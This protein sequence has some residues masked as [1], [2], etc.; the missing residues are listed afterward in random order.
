[1]SLSSWVVV[2]A[3]IAGAHPEEGA[4][5]GAAGVEAGD[6]PR[7]EDGAAP[8]FSPVAVRLHGGPFALIAAGAASPTL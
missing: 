1:M 6:A 3:V 7:A 2:L 8:L 4:A 5:S